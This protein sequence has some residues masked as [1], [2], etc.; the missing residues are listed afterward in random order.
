MAEPGRMNGILGD[1]SQLVREGGLA[2]E[3]EALLA[4]PGSDEER[5]RGDRGLVPVR[6]REPVISEEPRAGGEREVMRL[7]SDKTVVKGPRA[8][9][10][11]MEGQKSE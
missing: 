3:G 2:L 5:E 4:A 6:I 7:S 10:G 11:R 9:W 1:D 8:R